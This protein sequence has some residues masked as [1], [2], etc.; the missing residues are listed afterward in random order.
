ML[1]SFL[2]SKYSTHKLLMFVLIL[3][4]VQFCNILLINGF[5]ESHMFNKL[6]EI[7]L[8]K[9]PKTPALDCRISRAL[10]PR[11]VDKNVSFF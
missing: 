3:N 7:A 8:S 2:C 9:A 1:H 11:A 4:I 5:S 10:E 6:E